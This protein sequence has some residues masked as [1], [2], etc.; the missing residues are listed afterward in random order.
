[1]SL[2]ARSSDVILG[3][4]TGA[5]RRTVLQTATLSSTCSQCLAR[6]LQGSLSAFEDRNANSNDAMNRLVEYRLTDKTKWLLCGDSP[7]PLN[8]GLSCVLTSAPL[9][10]WDLLS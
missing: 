4:H 10:P 3:Q 5:R 8:E 6:S 7:E 9:E 2:Q 1:M